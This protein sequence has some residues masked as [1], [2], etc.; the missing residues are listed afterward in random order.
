MYGIWYLFENEF[1]KRYG[2]NHAQMKVFND[3]DT[4]ATPFQTASLWQ[5]IE[6]P[7][8]LFPGVQIPRTSIDNPFDHRIRASDHFQDFYND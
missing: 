5:A 3:Q 1:E 8:S 4:P 6:G 7:R 2:G